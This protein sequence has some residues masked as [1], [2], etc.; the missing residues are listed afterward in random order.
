MRRRT[1]NR[2]GMKREKGR[3]EEEEEEGK[4]RR[5]GEKT[6]LPVDASVGMRKQTNAGG[7]E[8]FM[9]PPGCFLPGWKATIRE[10][11]RQRC[12]CLCA[13]LCVARREEKGEG[14]RNND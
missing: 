3:D 5:T 4:R 12:V 14:R 2:P 7:N 9:E 1:R 8:C 10:S 11:A 6:K 13:S